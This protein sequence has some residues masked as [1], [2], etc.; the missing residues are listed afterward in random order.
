MYG[1][2]RIVERTIRLWIVQQE[3]NRRNGAPVAQGNTRSG[4]GRVANA[5]A[6]LGH[7]AR[8]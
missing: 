1:H 2:T 8:R 4:L 6:Q 5:T 7:Q 3:L